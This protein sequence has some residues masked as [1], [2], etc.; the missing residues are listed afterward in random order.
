MQRARRAKAEL[1]SR[2]TTGK[3]VEVS[4]DTLQRFVQENAFAVV[5][6]WAA[7]CAPCRILA[8]IID[9]LSSAYTGRIAFGK[10]NVDENQG[11]VTRYQ[12]MTIPTLLVFKAGK[13]VDQ[14][15]GV[16]PRPQLESR[17]TRYL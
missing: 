3:P 10:L 5:D 16:M 4:D 14:F 15:V 8:P 2:E 13:L 6:C 12:V 7:W 11:T 17:M 1:R 9:E